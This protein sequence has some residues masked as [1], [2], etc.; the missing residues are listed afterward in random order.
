MSA[1]LKPL[2]NSFKELHL[3]NADKPDIIKQLTKL[4][5]LRAE[6]VDDYDFE[7]WLNY[8][9][10]NGYSRVQ[11]L[12]MIE[13]AKKLP[14]YGTVK[15]AIGDLITNWEKK[16]EEIHNISWAAFEKC[17]E[18]L[19][20]KNLALLDR[21]SNELLGIGWVSVSDRNKMYNFMLWQIEQIKKE[22]DI[23][24]HENLKINSE[25]AINVFEKIKQET[26]LFNK[27]QKYINGE[28][29]KALEK[30]LEYFAN[31][32]TKMEVVKIN[33]KPCK[34]YTGGDMKQPVYNITK[35]ISHLR[36]LV[37]NLERNG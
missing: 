36:L 16:Q 32:C 33:G 31:E 11:V 12:E 20:Q 9:Q 24:E 18:S 10:E 30:E 29:K 28:V 5:F 6:E 13:L 14:K 23:V 26:R 4:C 21:L 25:A 1:T 8:W 3:S 2:Q 27:A 17:L 15:L 37:Y 7:I 19:L 35:F 22:K 34:D